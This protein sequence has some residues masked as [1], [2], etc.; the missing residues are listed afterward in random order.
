MAWHGNNSKQKRKRMRERAGWLA[1]LAGWVWSEGGCAWNWAG[2]KCRPL[3]KRER[4]RESSSAIPCPLTSNRHRDFGRGFLDRR[5]YSSSPLLFPSPHRTQ[6]L[7]FDRLSAPRCVLRIGPSR[8]DRIASLSC[9]AYTTLLLLC[10]YLRPISLGPLSPRC[11]PAP[12]AAE[13]L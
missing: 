2:W 5:L 3:T 13:A 6:T 1:G 9:P 11:R 4:E 12:L 8:V 7:S 10:E